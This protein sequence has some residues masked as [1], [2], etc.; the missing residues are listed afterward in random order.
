[1]LAIEVALADTRPVP[2][3]RLRRGRRGRRRQGGGGDRAPAGRPREVVTGP[4]RHAPAPGRGVRGPPCRRTQ[5]QRRERHHLGPRARS[6]TPAG[7]RS[8]PGCSPASRSPTPRWRTR[9]SCSRW[10]RSPDAEVGEASASRST[11]EPLNWR[12]SHDRRRIVGRLESRGEPHILACP[13]ALWAPLESTGSPV[14]STAAD[15][16]RLRHRRRRLVPRQ[17]PHRLQPGSPAPLPRAAGHDAEARP[18]PQRRPRDDE[19]VPARR[20]VR[21][22]RRRRDRPRHRSLRAVPGHRP[23]PDRQRHHRAGLLAR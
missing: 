18:L 21:H 14:G 22:Q 11:R 1:M 8:S 2:D 3:V 5:V 17:G 19:P 7:C 4:R 12:P 16:A 9:R 23:R 15:Q 20:G 10:P 6:T 13:G